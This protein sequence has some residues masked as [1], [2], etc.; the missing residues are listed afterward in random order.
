MIDSSDPQLQGNNIKDLLIYHYFH[1]S[2]K[3]AT[4]LTAAAREEDIGSRR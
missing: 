3:I 4:A 1:L 2:T